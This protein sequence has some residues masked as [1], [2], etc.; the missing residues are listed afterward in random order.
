MFQF[1]LFGLDYFLI[2]NYK[3]YG[4]EYKTQPVAVLMVKRANETV[5]HFIF[6]NVEDLYQ[7][8]NFIETQWRMN[9]EKNEIKYKEMEEARQ[10]IQ[11]HALYLAAEILDHELSVGTQMEVILKEYSNCCQRLVD[12]LTKSERKLKN[13]N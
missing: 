4:L 3:A 6:N 8:P 10:I 7:Y 2:S 13:K 11:S 12:Y 5:S 9:K 1:S